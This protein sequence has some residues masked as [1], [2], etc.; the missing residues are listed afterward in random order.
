MLLLTNMDPRAACSADTR[1]YGST[2]KQSVHS[3]LRCTSAFSATCVTR[4]CTCTH[5][6]TSPL[7]HTCNVILFTVVPAANC[8]Q[9]AT[10]SKRVCKFKQQLTCYC[11]SDRVEHKRPAISCE[12]VRASVS[13]LFWLCSRPTLLKT[14]HCACQQSETYCSSS[15]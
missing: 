14:W 8:G 13:G 4:C 2:H 11:H 1:R 6:F 7:I 12:N 9:N 5:S 15:R 3:E 10:C